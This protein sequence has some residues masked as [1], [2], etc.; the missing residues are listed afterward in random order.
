MAAVEQ[1]ASLFRQKLD[2]I[3]SKVEEKLGEKVRSLEP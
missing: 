1:K 3:P 2:T